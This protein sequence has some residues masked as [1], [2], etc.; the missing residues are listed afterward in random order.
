M[1]EETAT[2]ETENQPASTDDNQSLLNLKPSGQTEVE[3]EPSNVPHLNPDPDAEDKVEPAK[4]TPAIERPENIPEQFWDE[5]KGE[6]DTEQLAKGYSELRKK[7]DTGKHKP[8]KDGKYDLEDITK[9]LSEPDQEIFKDDPVLINY[10]DMAKDEGLSQSV[11]ERTLKIYLEAQGALSEAVKDA[12]AHE[13]LKLGRNS[14][15]I[16]ENMETWFH[17][18]NKT[19]VLSDDE[20][21]ALGQASRSALYVSAM[22]KIRRSY[23]EP[24]VPTVASTEIPTTNMDDFT[25][26][27]ADPLYGQDT[28]AGRAHTKKVEDMAYAMSGEQRPK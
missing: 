5:K 18:L 17:K 22:N 1:S 24:N 23:N 12:E 27:M 7:M 28:A 14:D 19:G 3:E 8:P 20:L 26:A 21:G 10:L 2:V 16:I 13:R 15:R 9:G 11:V 4:E 25:S 6:V